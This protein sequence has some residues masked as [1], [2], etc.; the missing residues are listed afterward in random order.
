MSWLCCLPCPG[1]DPHP[2]LPLHPASDLASTVLA[3]LHLCLQPRC[4]SHAYATSTTGKAG[5]RVGLRDS[6]R[7]GVQAEMQ[8][9][10]DPIFRTPSGSTV[11][12]VDDQGRPHMPRATLSVLSQQFVRGNQTSA[13]QGSLQ[14][15][16]RAIY[17]EAG[18][19]L[20]TIPRML[21]RIDTRI[22]EVKKEQRELLEIDVP[23]EQP[24]VSN[25]RF[26]ESVKVIRGWLRP[27]FSL[28]GLTHA[29]TFS[30]PLFFGPPPGVHLLRWNRFVARWN[31]EQVQNAS[32]TETPN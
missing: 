2:P 15:T 24:P 6:L 13:G 20:V 1:P 14:L 8:E 22:A 19:E 27:A 21:D 18:D 4:H 11:F 25:T 17:G 31:I 10:F 28:L 9:L 30:M 23:A 5:A 26:P 3:L 29:S 12:G 32:N 16:R 7:S